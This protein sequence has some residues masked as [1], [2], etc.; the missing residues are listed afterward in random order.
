VTGVTYDADGERTAM[1]D[2]TGTSSWT[3]DTLHRMTSSHDA[4]GKVVR[5]GYDLAGHLTSLTFPDGSVE[6]KGYDPAGNMYTIDYGSDAANFWIDEDGNYNE[7]DYPNGDTALTT[8]DA[9]DRPSQV[10]QAGWQ[11]NFETF[12]YGRDG[13][14]QV[15]TEQD[16]GTP[17]TAS[18]TYTY[19]SLNQLASTNGASYAYDLADN[20]TTSPSGTV[21]TYNADDEVVSSSAPISLVTSG[22]AEDS[23]SASSLTVPLPVAA[24]TGDQILAV[25]TEATSALASAPSGYSTVTTATSGGSSVAV[26]RRSATGGEQQVT[27]TYP[28]S[29]VAKTL[30]VAVYRGVDPVN[31]IEGT[32]SGSG[33]LTTTVTTPSVTTSQPTDRL[34]MAEAAEGNLQPAAWSAPSGMSDVIHENDLS[35]VSSAL[36]D[37]YPMPVGPSG[38]RTATFGTTGN[39]VGVLMALKP[40]VTTYTYDLRGNRTSV[41][42][43]SGPTTTLTYDQE[44]RL[45]GYGTTSYAYNGDGLRMRKTVGGTTTPY[46]YNLAEGLPLILM[47]GSTRFLYGPQ[48]VPYEQTTVVP[49]ATYSPN[50][51]YLHQDQLGTTRAI[52]DWLG[53]LLSTFSY[54]AYGTP[55]GSTGTTT[56]P[57]GFGGEYT[58]AESG[59]VYLRARYYDPVTGQFLSRDPLA[60][61]TSQPYAYAGDNPVNAGDPSGLF[62]W[63]PWSS[64]CQVDLP[65]GNCLANGAPTC[66]HGDTGVANLKDNISDPNPTGFVA[67]V[68]DASVVT[69]TWS[70]IDRTV[71]GAGNVGF[72]DW[73]AIPLDL[74]PGSGYASGREIECGEN[75]RISPLGN[76]GAKTAEGDANW[77]ARLPHYH[78]RIV[79]PST[80]ET[81]PGGSMKWHRPWQGW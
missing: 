54:D 69:A 49:P 18:S 1:T 19:S 76:W 46:V 37:Q 23:G 29:L 50:V 15:T 79:D 12:S 11:S 22:R 45:V 30:L 43:G 66:S 42:V 65:G 52:S 64:S 55:T 34:V 71:S 26:Y 16:T 81:V 44:D 9:S 7:T 74:L 48:G 20:R 27:V 57:M 70:D 25:S 68:R 33:L 40:V 77:A 10:T 32:T 35:M 4:A 6:S 78:R 17:G 5:Y 8:Y 72:W 61:R 63:P 47:D 38:S 36:A 60:S 58:D 13:N 2:G 56:T 41:S 73:A 62:C 14:G 39:L 31:P 3:W 67:A 51:Q 75:L 24:Q 21:Q 59:F 80:G 53:N 28:S